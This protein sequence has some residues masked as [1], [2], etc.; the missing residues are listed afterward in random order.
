M[1]SHSSKFV[2]LPPWE[3]VEAFLWVHRTGSLSAAGRSLGLTQPTVRR[4]IASLEHHLSI[5]LF[6]RSPAGLLPTPA[7]LALVPFAETM[8]ANAHA[9][10][11]TAESVGG[12]AGTVRIT[13]SEIVGSEVLPRVLASLRERHPELAIELV[14]SD[15]RQDLLRRD[16][17]VAVRMT[18][19]TR[20]GLVA[21]RIGAVEL[22]FFATA[23]VL[24]R[25]G[26]PVV[27]DDLRDRPLVGYDRDPR[28]LD[29]LAERGLVLRRA[30][31]AVRTDD[32]RAVLAA[33]RAGLGIGICQVPLATGLVRVLPD[34]T[35]PLEMWLVVHEDLKEVPRIRAV[36]DGLAAGLTAYVEGD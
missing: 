29:G 22:G 31:F 35:F 36:F 9:L 25:T 11:R 6:S 18:R 34:L 14:L 30:D 1:L 23:E 24:S 12:A 3:L 8:E 19:P 7:A 28:L 15:D 33:I 26:M 2:E 27:Q 4:R 10:V 5:S 17:D 21:R 32:D 13:A 16:A 20:V